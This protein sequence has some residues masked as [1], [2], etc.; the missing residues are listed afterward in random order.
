VK[1]LLL[2]ISYSFFSR[3]SETVIPDSFSDSLLNTFVGIPGE[4]LIL[5]EASGFDVLLDKM[6]LEKFVGSILEENL[7]IDA[8]L[9]MDSQQEKVNP[10]RLFHFLIQYF[11]QFIAFSSKGNVAG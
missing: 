4:V 6:R 10:P 5:I 1:N 11:N 9:S 8:V 7:V 3:I 2:K